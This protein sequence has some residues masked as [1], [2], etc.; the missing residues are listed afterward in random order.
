M[1]IG[2]GSTILLRDPNLSN[3]VPEHLYF[4]VSD[5]APDGK[6]LLVNVTKYDNNPDKSCVIND[7]E[8]PFIRHISV[9]NYRDA[10][11]TPLTALEAAIEKGATT[12]HQSATNVLLKRIQDGAKASNYLKSKFKRFYNLF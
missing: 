6:V 3:S 12:Q 10:I 2:K 7:R 4:V 11:E 9:V 5:V 1:S 8:H